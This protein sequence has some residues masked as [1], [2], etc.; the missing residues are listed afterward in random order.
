MLHRQRRTQHFVQN[1][2]TGVVNS[3]IHLLPEMNFSQIIPT[4][5]FKKFLDEINVDLKIRI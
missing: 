4:D 2:F 5:R 1:S 3:F